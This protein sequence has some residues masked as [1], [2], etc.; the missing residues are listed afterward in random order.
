MP[1]DAPRHLRRWIAYGLAVLLIALAVVFAVRGVDLSTLSRAAPSDLLLIAAAV[2]V[3]LAV[4]GLLFWAVTRPF[5][6]MPPVGPWRMIELITLSGLL[7]YVPVVRPG[8]WGRA[9]YLKARHGLPVRQ[10]VLILAVVLALAAAVLGLVSVVLLTLPPAARWW[11]LAASLLVLTLIA[12]PIAQRVFKRPMPWAWTWVPLRFLDL[13]V[14][15]AR[16]VLA[17]AVVG[18]PLSYDAALVIASASLLVKLSGLTPNG[19]GLNAWVVAAVATATG[20]LDPAVGVAAALVD[21][22]VEVLVMIPAGGLA[23]WRLR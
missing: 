4:T 22:A 9:A 14:A 23:A 7:N 3:N 21:R 16:L 15:A 11:V 10:S 1:G 18:Q 20:G 13:L 17:F 19:L 5:D 2:L 6:A 12:P 8:L